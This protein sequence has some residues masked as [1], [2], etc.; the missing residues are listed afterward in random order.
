MWFQLFEKS[1]KDAWHSWDVYP[2]ASAKLSMSTPVVRDEEK[3]GL[4]RSV[5][6]MYDRSSSATDN[7]GVRL[8]M[9]AHK[10]V[11]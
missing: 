4:Q 6:S 11:I 3:N 8:D 5:I 9:F 2:E 1:K 7:D 10:Q